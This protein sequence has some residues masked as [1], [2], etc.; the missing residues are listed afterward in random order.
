M[1]EN[2]LFFDAVGTLIRPRESIS[3]VYRRLAIG[4]GLELDQEVVRDR[5]QKARHRFFGDQPRQVSSESIERDRWRQLVQ[6]V[7]R[8]LDDSSRLFD[9]LWEYY[10]QPGNWLLFSDVAAALTR[11]L[12]D[13][14]P[15]AIASNFDNRLLGICRSLP[16]LQRIPDVFC[17]SQTGYCKPDLRFFSVVL[18]QLLESRPE[19]AG[20]T[21]VMIGDDPEKDVR[22]ARQ[23]G[24]ESRLLD[25]RISDFPTTVADLF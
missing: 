16:P 1:P 22:A 3:A 5:F 19:L 10:R 12:D 25:R 9:E 21:P 14:I 23:A 4:Q 13:G 18:A 11:M 6:D 24:W 7:F 17:S 8:E 20:W 2:L 15:I